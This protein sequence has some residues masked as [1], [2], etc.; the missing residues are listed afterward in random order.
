MGTRE[1]VVNALLDYHFN[2]DKGQLNFPESIEYELVWLKMLK[3]Y[4]GDDWYQGVLEEFFQRLEQRLNNENSGEI[5]SEE[6][7]FE[8]VSGEKV[9]K[10]R[11]YIRGFYPFQGE[12]FPPEVTWSGGWETR[13]TENFEPTEDVESESDL[14]PV[15][16][17]VIYEASN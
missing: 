2:Q 17:E 10:V 7:F 1:T 14:M 9:K 4:G 3:E 11:R 8:Q 5:L 12:L 13:V 15:F 16:E 6:V